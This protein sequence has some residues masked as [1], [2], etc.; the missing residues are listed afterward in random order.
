MIKFDQRRGITFRQTPAVGR[1]L[2][3]LR[4]VLERFLQTA[5]LAI[6]LR[7]HALATQYRIELSTSAHLGGFEHT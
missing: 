4:P 3:H 6:T 5:S 1:D 7:N 2:N